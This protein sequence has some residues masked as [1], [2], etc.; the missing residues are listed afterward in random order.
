MKK[1]RQRFLTAFDLAAINRLEAMV[2][3]ARHTTPFAVSQ[4]RPSFC[5]FLFMGTGRKMAPVY[6]RG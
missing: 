2:M 1:K 5:E 6:G 4:L 3:T